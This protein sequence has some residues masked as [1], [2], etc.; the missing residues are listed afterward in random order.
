MGDF[1]SPH[2]NFHFPTAPLRPY[3]PLKGEVRIFP[4]GLF[5]LLESLF[6]KKHN[7]RMPSLSPKCAF[8]G[9]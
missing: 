7:M 6:R 5:I 4:T 3:T 9:K 2:I 8:L 1:V